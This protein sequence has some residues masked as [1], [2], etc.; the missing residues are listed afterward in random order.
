M[1]ENDF[2]CLRATGAGAKFT[3]PLTKEELNFVGYAFVD[4]TDLVTTGRFP[5][6]THTETQNEMQQ[7]LTHW[8]E[9]LRITGGALEP[10]KTFWYLIDF[11]WDNG[12]WQYKTIAESPGELEV[13]NPDGDIQE[14]ERVE[15][16]EARR[17][18]GVRLAPDG[19]NEAEI[20]YLTEQAELWADN[21]R[22]NNLDQR[23][24]WQSLTTTIMAKLRY[25]LTAT[26]MTEDECSSIDKILLQTA[27]PRSGILPT[28]SRLLTYSPISK[29]GLGY[30]RLYDI[31]GAQGIANTIRHIGSGSITG[32]L[33][34]ISMEQ[35]QLEIGGGKQLFAQKWER[36]NC[37]LTDTYLKHLWRFLSAK[38]LNIT[39]PGWQWEVQRKG[40]QLLMPAMRKTCD[41]STLQTVNKCRI[42]LRAM[43]TA[44][45]ADNAGTHWTEDAWNGVRNK[46]KNGWPNQQRPGRKDWEIWQAVLRLTFG[47]GKGLEERGDKQKLEEQL[48]KWI[49]TD[50]GE[51]EYSVETDT[52]YKTGYPITEYKRT[53]Q[54]QTRR[55]LGNFTPTTTTKE[56]P[57]NT[58]KAYCIRTT[59]GIRLISAVAR[60]SCRNKET[61]SIRDYM[62]D[63]AKEYEWMHRHVRWPNDEGL[64]IA[65][66]I[67]N[68]QCIAVSDGSYK[69]G[70]GTASAVI[71]IESAQIRID[72]TTPGT[73][74]DQCSYRSEL[75]GLH[76]AIYH[77]NLLCHHHKVNQG[78]VI[79]ACDG[80]S[81]I[82]A[83]Q[84]YEE[85][86]SPNVPHFDLIASCRD[87]L[88]KS[89]IQWKFKHVYGHQNTDTTDTFEQLNQAMDSACKAHWE[90]TNKD[91]PN[92]QIISPHE[93]GVWCEN[94]KVTSDLN[95]TI[96][97]WCGEQY[98]T[99]YWAKRNGPKVSTDWVVTGALMKTL[100]QQRKKWLSKQS[101]GSFASG[102]MMKN[103]QKRLTDECPRCGRPE[104]SEHILRCNHPKANELWKQHA[105]SIR[106]WATEKQSDPVLICE[107]IQGIAQWRA[108]EKEDP[109]NQQ[110]RNLLEGRPDTQWRERQLEYWQL[111]NPR[112]TS[113]KLWTVQ[114]SSKL[115][116]FT[117]KLWEQRNEILHEK[118]SKLAAEV[119]DQNNQ[120]LVQAFKQITNPTKRLR[121]L[122]RQATTI[123]TKTITI[124]EHW[125]HV[126]KAA[127]GRE[128][129]EQNKR[130]EPLRRQQRGLQ[131]W[132]KST[133]KV[134]REARRD[135]L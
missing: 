118:D 121:Q 122:I 115:V 132:L 94:R 19:N 8:E 65:K 95:R 105:E 34:R 37:L 46:H 9:A 131:E 90:L 16:T 21:V 75:A 69:D 74:T 25:P 97:Q 58:Q 104:N 35:A 54:R 78:T 48:T 73:T 89:P 79:L 2:N 119:I 112:K 66:G 127:I 47:D 53:A 3:S 29:Q 68:N 27:L 102:K 43:S 129:R 50:H 77:T 51:W 92:D 130:N 26:T 67:G 64:Q 111:L 32:K 86:A 88:R 72:V 133:Q 91:E 134:T 128:L 13:R 11:K 15:T 60:I 56:I 61:T 99:E 114:L 135:D 101:A 93:W 109:N 83:I 110:W 100:P 81:A 71:A 10:T 6:N 103:R 31:Q 106:V 98:A 76:A 63:E 117:W 124:K 24:V 5:Q 62:D 23:Y 87:L 113:A 107:I 59:E 123:T 41:D 18:L 20:E 28:F 17:T 42:Y 52:V 125:N 80:K 39:G 7:A 108:T 30:Q 36:Y 82:E 55:N 116:E 4:D 85:E 14:I 49:T 120:E 12:N 45:I 84:Y 70:H 22:T 44:D 1:K 33:L 126:V 38:R 40:D 96:M 57:P